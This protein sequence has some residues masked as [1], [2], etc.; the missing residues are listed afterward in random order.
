MR[1]HGMR[2]AVR[3]AMDEAIRE[4]TERGIA[5]ADRRLPTDRELAEGTYW[6]QDCPARQPDDMDREAG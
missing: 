3:A 1:R 4:W 2:A 5:L 6:G